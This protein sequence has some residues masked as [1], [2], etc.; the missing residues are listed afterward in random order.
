MSD[1]PR[2]AAPYVTAPGPKSPRGK[3]FSQSEPA[4]VNRLYR[5][6]WLMLLYIAITILTLIPLFWIRDS[7]ENYVGIS[8]LIEYILYLW[9]L[10][11]ITSPEPGTAEPAITLRSV[12]RWS[13]VGGFLLGLAS[14]FPI[15]DLLVAV[16]DKMMLLV[17]GLSSI[18]LVIYLRHL[19]MKIPDKR[20]VKLTTIILWGILILYPLMGIIAAS[21]Y[22]FSDGFDAAIYIVALG[23]LAL[24]GLGL[25]IMSLICLMKFNRAFK[26]LAHK[27]TA[28]KPMPS[29]S[30]T[31]AVNWVIPPKPP[32]RPP[33]R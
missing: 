30:T 17:G 32:P 3:L 24:A 6:T 23:A 13:N 14:L 21:V 11:C 12:L 31:L 29:A 27:P 18:G 7:I 25:A 28:R 4:W 8:L 20:L 5:G 2:S 15:P 33:V 10:F 1:M 9:S 22:L 26:R 16:V 19:A